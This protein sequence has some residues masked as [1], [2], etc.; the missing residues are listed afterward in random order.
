M[1]FECRRA[2]DTLTP[3]PPCPSPRSGARGARYSSLGDL[4]DAALIR[5]T[6]AGPVGQLL[7]SLEEEQ[8]RG[9]VAEKPERKK[10]KRFLTN[11]ECSAFS[12]LAWEF[13]AT[14]PKKKLK[15]LCAQRVAAPRPGLDS[16]KN[17]R[18]AENPVFPR[19]QHKSGQIL[20]VALFASRRICYFLRVITGPT[21]RSASTILYFHRTAI[22]MPLRI[23]A[24]S[25]FPHLK[26]LR[27]SGLC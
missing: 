11:G 25:S 10:A 4:C 17:G 2:T 8:A 26:L 20:R 3:F 18:F 13:W 19:V 21:L 12:C 24:V 23:S 6:Q 27:A 16:E 14:L 15:K 1:T 9:L 22:G 5:Q 7:E